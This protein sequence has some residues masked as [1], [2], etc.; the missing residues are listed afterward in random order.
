MLFFGKGS[1]KNKK[2]D[3]AFNRV[4]QE[5]Q[6]IEDWDDPKKLEHYILDACEQIIAITKEIEGE[7]AEYRIVTS[8]L[9]DIQAIEKLP[10]NRMKELKEVASNIVDLN[11]ARTNYLKSSHNIT[12]EQF[13]LMEQ[14]EEDVPAIIHRM[15]EHERYQDA[16]KKDK[17]ILETQKNQWEMERESIIGK[18]KL[19]KRI[20]VVLFGFYATLL[21]L[22]FVIQE[23]SNFDLTIGYLI[24]FFIGGFGAF[25][26]YMQTNFMRRDMRQAVRN[27]NQSVSMLNVVRMKYANVTKS[28]EYTK[29]KFGVHSSTELN[30]VWEQYVDAVK[31]RER[32][33]KNNDDLEYFNGRMMRLLEKVNLHDRRIWLNQAKALVDADE[34]MEIKH[35]L[36][37]RRQKIRD[38]IEDNRQI[39]RSE[40]NEIDQL[41]KEHEHYVPEIVEIIKSVDKLCGLNEKES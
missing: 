16:V 2:L 31:E 8:Y 1:K 20:G 13:L 41:M 26:I 18:R 32:F 21:V 30:Y 17:N 3:D 35:N 11:N 24:L 12:E 28:V 23:F 9:T 33:E 34:M 27:Y 38:H 37:K 19:L 40:R 4:Y 15:L 14:E 6:T 29:D 36:V 22:L 25:G 5:I 10:E 7:R 39:V